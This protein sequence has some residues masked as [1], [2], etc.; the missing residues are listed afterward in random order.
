MKDEYIQPQISILLQSGTFHYSQK[1]PYYSQNYFFSGVEVD[2]EAAS[3]Y[4]LRMMELM[5]MVQMKNTMVIS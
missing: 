1:K 4:R 3:E 5:A 2:Q